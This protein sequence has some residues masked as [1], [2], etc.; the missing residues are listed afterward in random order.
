[1]KQLLVL[2]C[3]ALFF[4]CNNPNGKIV[5]TETEWSGNYEVLPGA[6]KPTQVMIDYVVIEPT[7]GQSIYYA[8]KSGA[9]FEYFAG[10]LTI[11]IAI[12]WAV[13]MKKLIIKVSLVNI[14]VVFLMLVGGLAFL[15][16]AN[17]TIRWNNQ[18]KV[19][20]KWY[21]EHSKDLKA[22]WDEL[23]TQKKIVG[24]SGK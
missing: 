13:L 12:G 24:T 8:A 22:M 23:Y 5:R 4:S 10:L 1:M 19:E 7:W 20:K 16:S 14:I 9:K 15:F 21:D 17:S 18:I 6:N 2:M 11:L 3:A